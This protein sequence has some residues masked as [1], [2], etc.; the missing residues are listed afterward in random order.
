MIF[1]RGGLKVMDYGIARIIGSP[2][3][4]YSEAYLGTPAYSAPEST[5]GKVDQQSDLYSLGIIL[6]RMLTGDTPF[7]STNP[8]EILDMHRNATLPPFPPE[9]EMPAE[10]YR[11]VQTLT[12]KEKSQRYADA[13][14]FLVDLNGVLKKL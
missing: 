8:L 7:R 5:S 14:S 9:L 3:L 13:E 10:V 12:A 6:F 11:L 4:T 2:G 1:K